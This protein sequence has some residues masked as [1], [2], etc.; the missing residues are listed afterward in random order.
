MLTAI[1]WDM[2]GTLVDTEPL[3]GTATYELSELLGRRLTPEL[4]ELTVG[5]SFPNTLRICAEHAGVELRAGD[6]TRYRRHLFD[7]MGQLLDA[8]LTP[9]PGIPELLAS[10][11]ARAIPMLVTTNTERELADPSIAAV[12]DHFFIDSVAGDEVPRPKP[13]P[14]MYLE[15]ARR[16]NAAPGQCLVF[17]DSTAGMTAAVL[18]GCRVIGLPADDSTPVPEGVVTLRE[19]HGCSSLEGVSATDVLGWFDHLTR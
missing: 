11:H 5:G 1:F 9:N 7:R 13:A 8:H 17:E 2:D 18:A 19:L 14:D 3:W 15:A 4:R 16:V 10:L 6:H 12:G